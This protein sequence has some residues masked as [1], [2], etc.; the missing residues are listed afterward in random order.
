M[1]TL[2]EEYVE[3]PAQAESHAYQGHVQM[4]ELSVDL[5][6]IKSVAVQSVVLGAVQGVAHGAAQSVKQGV[7]RSENVDPHVS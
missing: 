2:A 6:A 3:R 7:G 1:N 5:S 4:L